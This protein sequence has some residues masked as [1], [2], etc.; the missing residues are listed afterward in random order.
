MRSR[1]RTGVTTLALV[2]SLLI[3]PPV[4]RAD[5]VLDWNQIMLATIGGQSPFVQARVGAITQLAV[6]EAVNAIDRRY[7]PYLGTI[8]SGAGASRSAAAVAAPHTVLKSYFPGQGASLDAARASSLAA[9]Q[10]GS[11]KSAGIAVVSGRP[12]N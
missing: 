8:V 2:G 7:Q 9:I 4:A 5:V 3:L 6:F 1:T 11:A 12:P 10:D